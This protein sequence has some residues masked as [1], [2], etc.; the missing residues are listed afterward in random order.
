MQNSDEAHGATLSAVWGSWARYVYHLDEERFANY[1]R[2]VWNIDEENDEKTAVAAIEK[3]EEFFPVF[4]V[5]PG[6]CLGD[7]KMGVQPDEEIKRN[8]WQGDR[9]GYHES[10]RFPEN[11]G[12]RVI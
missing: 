4:A 8:G 7:M 9:R 10:G 11:G 3:T 6:A 1:G 2:K 12:K 5:M